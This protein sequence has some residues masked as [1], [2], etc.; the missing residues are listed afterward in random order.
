M[1]E[2]LGNASPVDS[3]PTP[4]G[5]SDAT[6]VVTSGADVSSTPERQESAPA[7]TPK[8]TA[9]PKPEKKSVNLFESEE[10]RRY[11]ATQARQIQEERQ[12]ADALAAQIREQKLKGMSDYEKIQF[13]KQ[14]SDQRAQ[15]LEQQL[16]QRELE[17]LK[18]QD[19]MRLNQ[20]TGIP[21]DMLE[22]AKSYEEAQDMAMEYLSTQLESTVEE[23][24]AAAIEAKRANKTDTGG[25]KPA[26][27]Q[28][29]R[30][31]RMTAAME[32]KDA[33]SYVAALFSED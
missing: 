13:A 12:R 17:D 19:M 3:T 27:V 21:L 26:P 24:V 10:F 18:R 14:E 4:S 11:Q 31:E 22:S 33:V 20:K 8:T 1:S 25:G 28:T 30:E 5:Q 2:E 16:K 15:A 7:E 6:P 32:S 9:K 23:R 29:Q